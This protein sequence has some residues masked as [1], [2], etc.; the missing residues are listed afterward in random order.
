MQKESCCG[1]LERKEKKRVDGA[2]PATRFFSYVQ[3]PL[4]P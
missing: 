2:A 3:I 1:R 4:A